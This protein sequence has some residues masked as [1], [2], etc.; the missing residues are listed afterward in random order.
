MNQ[1]KEITDRLGDFRTDK[2][3]LLLSALA[4]PIGMISALVAKALL[5]LIA[6]ITN[7]AFFQR[8]SV[9]P[10]LPQTHHLGYWVI[11]IGRAHV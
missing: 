9:S 2:R 11:E 3:M 4:V 8:L 5:W 6:L 7:L 1:H 10:I